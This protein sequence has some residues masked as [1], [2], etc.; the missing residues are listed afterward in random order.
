MVEKAPVEKDRNL[1]IK[2]LL[3]TSTQLKEISIEVRET[4]D[5]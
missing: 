3:T 4:D 5:I 1:Q 2:L